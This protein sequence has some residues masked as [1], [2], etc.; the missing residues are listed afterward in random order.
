M[1]G[2]IQFKNATCGCRFI[3]NMEEII[4]VFE[5]TRLR[6]DEASILEFGRER[7]LKNAN[8]F[9][10]RVVFHIHS[11]S[12]K[13]KTKRMSYTRK[14]RVNGKSEFQQTSSLPFAS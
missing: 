1:D 3:L 4:S 11:P 6:V 8:I 12:C 10:L 13:T 14:E 5:D 2:Q 9:N 7:L